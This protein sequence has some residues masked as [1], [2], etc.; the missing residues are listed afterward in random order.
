MFVTY[1]LSDNDV[2]KYLKSKSYYHTKLN[3]KN[4]T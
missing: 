4:A 2:F 1:I 3:K